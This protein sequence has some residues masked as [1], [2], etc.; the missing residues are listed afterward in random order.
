MSKELDFSDINKKDFL[1]KLAHAYLHFVHNYVYYNQFRITGREKLPKGEGYLVISNHQNSLNDALGILFST[2]KKYPVFIAR[3]DLFKKPAIAKFMKWVGIMPAYRVRDGIDE[4]GK[5]EAIFREAARVITEGDPIVLFPEALHQDGRYLGVFKK[6]FARIA[7]ETVEQTDFKMKLKIVPMANNYSDYFRFQSK[8]NIII[9]EP[10]EFD[11]LYEIYKTHP[12]RARYLLAQRAHDAVE[13][14]MVNL[15]DIPNYPALETLCT[16]YRKNYIKNNKIRPA[17]SIR[18]ETIAD[19]AMANRLRDC[20][21]N[22]PVQYEGLIVKAREYGDLL[23]ELKLRDWIFTKR[24]RPFI[25]I[26]LRTILWVLFIP[27]WLVCALLNFIPFFSGFIFTRKVKDKLL[28]PSFHFVVG[29]LIAGPLWYLI[30]SVV[31]AIV[32]HTWWYGV[33]AL[34]LLPFTV[35]IFSRSTGYLKKL[36]NRFRRSSFVAK[37]DRRFFRALDLREQ[38]VAGMDEL[39]KNNKQHNNGKKNRHNGSSAD[40]AQTVSLEG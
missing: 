22:N 31:L 11:D 4:L 21:N 17:N 30:V 19:Q 38:L 37:R 29:T 6:G 10:F 27:V 16:I 2:G 40:P 33:L 18:S 35:I 15:D 36:V 20:R 8:L 34:I 7:F 13:K 3:A 24:R 23:K 25:G 28:H 39:M 12:E 5:N 32:T 9:G 26:I 1:Y 14:L